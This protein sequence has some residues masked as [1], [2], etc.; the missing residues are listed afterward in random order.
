MSQ[1]DGGEGKTSARSS[2]TAASN[3]QPNHIPPSPLEEEE[4][5]GRPLFS[6]KSSPSPDLIQPASHPRHLSVYETVDG[7]VVLGGPSSSS[8]HVEPQKDV[9][10]GNNEEMA[11]TKRSLRAMSKLFS[12]PPGAHPSPTPMAMA[13]GLV[14][15]QRPIRPLARRAT[16]LPPRLSDQVTTQDMLPY[17][18][19]LNI[20]EDSLDETKEKQIISRTSAVI[21]LLCTTALVAVCAEFLV[22]SI[23]A[24]ISST[25]ISEAFVGLILLP[26]I[27]N[28]AEH[29]TAVTVA[30]KNKMDLAI[31][32][33][34]GS[35]IQIGMCEI[36]F[37]LHHHQLTLNQ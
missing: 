28:A 5:R 17:I 31:G 22:S 37:R 27:G 6:E 19:P 35:S 11:R 36:W 30:A 13:P 25:G 16:S 3:N 34:V 26:I 29:V 21:L 8:Q 33:A 10:E 23:D 9:Q 7:T 20:S 18:V 12:R 1:H 24:V 15:E 4:P 14:A 2:A 32:V